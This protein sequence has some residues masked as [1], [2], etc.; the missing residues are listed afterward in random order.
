M[1]DT[2]YLFPGS[3]RLKFCLLVVISY[4]ATAHS[5]PEKRKRR[6]KSVGNKANWGSAGLRS[7]WQTEHRR[8]ADPELKSRSHKV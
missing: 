7:F 5:L 4:V 2:S 8:A 1:D 6:A 3:R